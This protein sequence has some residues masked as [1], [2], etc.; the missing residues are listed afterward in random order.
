M[1]ALSV[2]IY[3]YILLHSNTPA[4]KSPAHLLYGTPFFAM[5]SYKYTN[6]PAHKDKQTI[7]IHLYDV[8]FYITGKKLRQ[9]NK[10][11]H[12]A[13]SVAIT[14]HLQ[15]RATEIGEIIIIHPTRDANLNPIAH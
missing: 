14:F 9:T 12:L 13:D 11:L 2:S 7:M 10:N 1:K 8:T 5:Q 6:T 15:K 3:C 4:D